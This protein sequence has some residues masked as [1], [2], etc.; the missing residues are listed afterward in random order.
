MQQMLKAFWMIYVARLFF[1][2]HRSRSFEYPER[3]KDMEVDDMSLG[4]RETSY[5]QAR[6]RAQT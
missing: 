5:G 4:H 2:A 1:A 6:P 3:W